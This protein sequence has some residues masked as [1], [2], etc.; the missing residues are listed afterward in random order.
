MF[1]VSITEFS[2]RRLQIGHAE[3][4]LVRP[5]GR[6]QPKPRPEEVGVSIHDATG[7]LVA[8]LEDEPR[9]AGRHFVTWNGRDANGETAASGVYFVR[10][11]AGE[12]SRSQK[13]VLQR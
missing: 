4:S 11:S 3:L 12:E 1:F 13:V 5:R 10:L 2:M 8:H 7:R 6:S 9:P